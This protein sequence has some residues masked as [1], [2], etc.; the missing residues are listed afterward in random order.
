[1]VRTGQRNEKFQQTLQLPKES[2]YLFAEQIFILKF[3]H[4][5][6]SFSAHTNRLP[7]S[8]KHFEMDE[9]LESEIHIE[10]N[11]FRCYFFFT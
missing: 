1:M 3:E 4:E 7:L 11:Q 5:C 8:H 6:S 10:S 2:A 9:I